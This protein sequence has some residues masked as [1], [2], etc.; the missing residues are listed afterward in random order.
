IIMVAGLGGHYLGTWEADVDGT[1]WPRDLLREH[2]DDKIEMRVFS[3]HYNTTLRG[4]TSKAGIRDHAHDLLSKLYD[5]REDDQYVKLRYLVFVGHSLGG[6]IIKRAITAARDNRKYRSIWEA[7]IGVMFFATPHN[8]LNRDAWEAFATRILKLDAPG[9]GVEPSKNMLKELNINS[10]ALRQITHDFW[11]VQKDMGF[12]TFSEDEPLEGLEDLLVER[13]Y[14]LSSPHADDHQML[15]GDHVS[16]CKFGREELDYFY[17]VAAG[18]ESLL[19]KVTEP[20]GLDKIKDRSKSAL[21][22]LGRDDYHSYFLDKKPTK[23]TCRWI[24][25]RP[26]VRAWKNRTS[27]KPNL[28]IR[29]PSGSGKS[30]LARQ[31]INQFSQN[32]VVHCF[33]SAAARDRSD[34]EALLRSTLQQILRLIPELIEKFLTPVFEQFNEH[35]KWTLQIL[36]AIWPEAVAEVTA[37]KPLAMVVEGFDELKKECQDGFLECLERFKEKSKNSENLRLLV[38]SGQDPELDAKLSQDEFDSYTVT[39][40]DVREDMRK[41]VKKKLKSRR[42]KGLSRK[43]KDNLESLC[44]SIVEKSRGS[45]RWATM[46][47]DELTPNSRDG[48]ATLESLPQDLPGLHLYRLRRLNKNINHLDR[49]FIRQALIWACFQCGG[50]K[51][52]EFNIGQ[53][54]GIALD[55]A[56]SHDVASHEWKRFALENVKAKLNRH[57]GQMIEIR[58]GRLE[59]VHESLKM[60]SCL[61][62]LKDDR[63]CRELIPDEETAHAVLA[64]ICIT[65]LTMSCFEDPGPEIDPD[66]K[67][68]WESKV[69]A[70]LQ[71]HEFLRYA[72]LHW[73]THLGNAGESW[74]DDNFEADQRR[75]WLDGKNTGYGKTWREV[76]WFLTQGPVR[77]YP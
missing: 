76:W 55:M 69:R 65:F 50:L 51:E 24:T 6:M 5:Q 71:E 53:A 1:V 41:T 67:H 66:R 19:K 2:I 25:T 72:V 21:Y 56:P 42:G 43:Y 47:A 22:S 33:L 18:I 34:L 29:G 12:V 10:N 15:S 35:S 77:D 27:E 13:V 59:L 38:I 45:Y 48:D 3:F 37:L 52:G 17:P 36:E 26:E 7:S 31:M 23:G 20:I 68:V 4:T 16:L 74:P 14:A 60:V 39:P 32:D 64:E 11:P 62:T 8:G 57:C 46:A 61:E 28:W 30:F 44:Q 9:E 70:R 75:K 58:D 73:Q 63:V 40:E 54:M 49:K